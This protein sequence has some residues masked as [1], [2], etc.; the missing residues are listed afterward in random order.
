VSDE[1]RWFEQL[2]TQ[3]DRSGASIALAKC[4]LAATPPERRALTDGWPF[5]AIWLYPNPARL[6]CQIGESFGSRDRIIASLILSYLE[7]AFGSKEQLIAISAA[8]RACEL[9][10]LDASKVFEDVAVALPAPPAEIL[11][12]FLRRDAPDRDPKAFGFVERI[13]KDGEVELDLRL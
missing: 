9:S 10:G 7:G 3:S 13:N 6:G 8:Y 2:R 1:P 12:A 11:R 5:G 4:F